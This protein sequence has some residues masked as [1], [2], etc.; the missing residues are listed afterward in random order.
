LPHKQAIE[1]H[2]QKR[3]GELFALEYDLLL[4]DVTSTYFEGLA[5][6]NSQ[7]QRG[8]SRDHR[9]DCKQVCIALVVT[10][11]GIPL[12]YEVFDGNRVASRH[13]RDQKDGDLSAWPR[14]SG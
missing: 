8:H 9:P 14:G 11:E 12:S 3:L 4:Y 7:A 13:G 5:A 2:L 10:R 1:A 6:G